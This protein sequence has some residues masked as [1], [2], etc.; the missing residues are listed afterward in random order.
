MRPILWAA[1][2]LALAV[3][4]APCL[5]QTKLTGP[6]EAI[7]VPIA[8]QYGEVSGA[9]VSAEIFVDYYKN[10]EK[11]RTVEE[12]FEGKTDARRVGEN[13]E[14]LMTDFPSVSFSNESHTESRSDM[15]CLM[16]TT[17]EQLECDRG[18]VAFPALDRPGYKTGDTVTFPTA[19]FNGTAW[20]LGGTVIGKS[21]IG[22]RSV[23]VVEFASSRKD[24]IE[25]QE[26]ET[27]VSGH[28]YLD[29]AV[30]YPLQ[31]ELATEYRGPFKGFDRVL[32]VLRVKYSLPG[33]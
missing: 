7:D 4:A 20:D 31:L 10:G 32:T 13:L 6:I 26:I 29:L 9:S 19:L 3:G 8:V 27:D 17:G 11:I 14:L 18:G 15:R 25:G 30:G 23:L 21:R 22:Q 33:A 2:A 1:A 12:R 28:G 24:K 16:R 5:A